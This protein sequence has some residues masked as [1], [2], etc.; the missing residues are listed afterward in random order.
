MYYINNNKV[1]VYHWFKNTQNKTLLIIENKDRSCHF[2]GGST[3]I[4]S[5]ICIIIYT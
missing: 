3:Y 2:T 5:I 4:K 1:Y